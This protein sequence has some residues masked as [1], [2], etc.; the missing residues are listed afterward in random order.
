MSDKNQ[1]RSAPQNKFMFTSVP[2]HGSWLIFL[3]KWLRC[4]L[5]TTW[6][7]SSGDAPTLPIFFLVV[8]CFILHDSQL[9][10]ASH[11]CHPVIS[12]S[13]IFLVFCLPSVL[14]SPFMQS[15]DCFRAGQWC[16][17]FAPVCHC[18]QYF[19][20]SG[21]FVTLLQ[22]IIIK[23]F[24][25]II[26]VLQMYDY[27]LL[28]KLEVFM[29]WVVFWF[30]RYSVCLVSFSSFLQCVCF[31]MIGVDGCVPLI[32]TDPTFS[33]FY[34]FTVILSLHQFWANSS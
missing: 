33:S 14:L 7:S 11:F 31:M 27:I 24:S 1:N 29:I 2:T 26:P 28:T 25:S 23:N 3:S 9:T 17:T 16:R 18:H 22:F 4:E 5:H 32:V 13:I 10:T 12:P 8:Y 20:D 15:V 6:I 19:H 21:R 30:F 34:N